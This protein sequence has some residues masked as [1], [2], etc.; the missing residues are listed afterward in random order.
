[1]QLGGPGGAAFGDAS[2]PVE[3]AA[4]A[5]AAQQAVR[6]RR[7]IGYARG[8]LLVFF[9]IA[10]AVVCPFGTESDAPSAKSGRLTEL[11]FEAHHR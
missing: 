6:V 7:R 8:A 11:D 5:N 3:A 10:L 2:A 4:E 9:F 1:M